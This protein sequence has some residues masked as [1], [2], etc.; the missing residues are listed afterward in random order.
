MATLIPFMILDFSL[1]ACNT[2]FATDAQGAGEVKGDKGGYGIVGLDITTQ[3]TLEIWSASFSPGKVITRLDGSLGHRFHQKKNLIPTIPFTRLP[4]FLFHQDWEILDFGR[5]NKA[6]HITLGEGRAHF[7]LIQSLAS[8]GDTHNARIVALQDNFAIS[9]SMS[10]GRS[11]APSLNYLVRRRSAHSLASNILIA[12]P[13]IETSLMPADY[14]SRMVEPHKASYRTTTFGP[15][16]RSTC[17]TKH[18]LAVPEGSEALPRVHSWVP[19]LS[20]VS[21]RV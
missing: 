21:S 17:A 4:R 9:G 19:V 13:W 5:W 20:G 18:T 2:I 16:Y 8:V 10:K 14:A 12:S 3:Q 6:D 11:P 7:K 1:K 15:D